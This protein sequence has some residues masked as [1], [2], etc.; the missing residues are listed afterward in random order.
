MMHR[1]K[2]SPRPGL[3]VLAGL[4][5]CAAGTVAAQ[6][7]VAQAS[8]AAPAYLYAVSATSSASAWAVGT[9]QTGSYSS[10]SLIKHW[11]G[12]SWSNVTAPSPGTGYNFLNGVSAASAT[13]AW[14][15]GAYNATGGVQLPLILRWN[16]T[17]WKQVASPNPGGAGGASLNGVSTLSATSAWAVGDYG[18]SGLSFI[19]HWDGTSWKRVASPNPGGTTGGT[20]LTGVSAASATSAWAVGSFHFSG[21]TSHSLV[22][23]WDG[24][25]WKQVTSANPGAQYT[26]LNA[27]SATPSGS[28]WAVGSYLT[29][30]ATHSQSL[31]EGWNGT[32]WSHSITPDPN[33]NGNEFLAAAA[34]SA[35]S[36]WA[37]GDTSPAAGGT[38]SLIA[39][40]N[41]TQWAQI[42][43][44]NPGGTA[45]Y[46]S[47]KAVAAT[48][49]T[50]AWAV[51]YANNSSGGSEQPVIFRWNG[52]SWTQVTA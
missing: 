17:S 9:A 2:L 35:T 22:L 23:H 48:S 39:R 46:T 15:V 50:S 40:W 5:A 25:S 32:S 4:A 52:T 31:A 29:S 7:S 14:A 20:F 47:L 18:A 28:A 49:A 26:G 13:S 38:H 19:L 11:N 33:P 43:S 3:A 42:A 27:V 36:A 51:G 6:A 34:L 41:G 21:K 44:P 30:S 12:T 16:G 10:R 45:G 37:V 1:H 24:T 8:A